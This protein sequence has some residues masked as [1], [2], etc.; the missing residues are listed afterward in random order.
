MSVPSQIPLRNFPSAIRTRMQV[1]L[2]LYWETLVDSH[3]GQAQQF[4]P[5]APAREIR[6]VAGVAQ[7]A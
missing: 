4:I 3:T 1:A 6:D 7:A 2:A 5:H